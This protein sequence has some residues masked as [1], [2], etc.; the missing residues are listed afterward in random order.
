MVHPAEHHTTGAGSP[1]YVT[2]QLGA[3]PGPD[4]PEPPLAIDHG[5]APGLASDFR[6]GCGV[7]ALLADAIHITGH[8][9]HTVGVV[10]HQV[11]FDQRAGHHLGNI[12][13]RPGGDEDGPAEIN[14]RLRL[15]SWHLLLL[16]VSLL[17]GLPTP[18]G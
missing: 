12:V 3:K 11:S 1:G 14:Q 17:Y 7:Q 6:A 8:P 13:W 5:N 10:P 18:P 4:L 9:Q 15:N 16:S 2:N